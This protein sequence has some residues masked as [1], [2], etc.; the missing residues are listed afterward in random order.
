MHPIKTPHPALDQALIDA[1]VERLRIEIEPD[2]VILFGS[3]ARG[4]MRPDSDIDLLVLVRNPTN[5]RELSVRFD[6]RL[7]DLPRRFDVRVLDTDWFEASKDTIGG[8][9]YPAHK[10]GVV[11]YASS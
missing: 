2:R 9:A 11:L 6:T 5:P 8:L 7:A 10:D 3:A 1:I 4:E